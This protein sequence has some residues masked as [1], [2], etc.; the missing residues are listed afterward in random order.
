MK[1]SGFVLFLNGVN[2]KTWP[3]FITAIEGAAR[4]CP[5]WRNYKENKPVSK[6]N[7][8]VGTPANHP[9]MEDR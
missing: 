8:A 7:H 4:N 3:L 2:K 6:W 9:D 5:M 1:H